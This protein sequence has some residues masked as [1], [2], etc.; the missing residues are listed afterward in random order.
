VSDGEVQRLT[1]QPEFRKFQLAAYRHTVADGFLEIMLGGFLLLFAA[2]SLAGP[3][4][5]LVCIL[6]ITSSRALRSLQRRFVEPRAGYIEPLGDK[7]GK[8]LP[9]IELYTALVIG[10]APGFLMLACG[11]ASSPR[12]Q[13]LLD[14][15]HQGEPIVAGIMIGSALWYLARRTEFMRFSVLTAVAV[16]AGAL[17]TVTG[18]LKVGLII[19]PGQRN[20]FVL[21]GL[22]GVL[23]L[24]SGAVAALRFRRQYP[25]ALA[26]RNHA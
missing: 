11:S 18:A 10:T 16:T 20:L 5:L 15:L 12:Y 7:P 22:L 4:V 8:V 6:P 3:L 1:L 26:G 23:V 2:L 14:Y 13:G 25:I 19:G 21:L 17:L 24:A 9:G